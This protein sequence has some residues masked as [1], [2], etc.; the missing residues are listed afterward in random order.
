VGKNAAWRVLTGIEGR[1]VRVKSE[2]RLVL[3]VELLS[4]S[5]ATEV[6]ARDVEPA[7]EPQTWKTALNTW[8]GPNKRSCTR[9]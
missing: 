3:S 4:P 2:T 1:L 9:I 6:D 7:C 8:G 5:V